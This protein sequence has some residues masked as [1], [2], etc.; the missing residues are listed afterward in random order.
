MDPAM[1]AFLE[2]M[3]KVAAT[4][5]LSENKQHYL[6]SLTISFAVL[7]AFFVILRFV[8]RAKTQQPYKWDDWL[9]VIAL[10][11]IYV[12]LGC[13]MYSKFVRDELY[14]NEYTKKL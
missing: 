5:D 12:N 8:S 7:A 6:T 1:L 3:G 11:L 14:L 13:M 9:I 4:Q 10:A 2:A